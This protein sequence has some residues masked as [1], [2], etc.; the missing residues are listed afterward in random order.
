MKKFLC[1]I[2]C[3][4]MVFSTAACSTN[5]ESTIV[6][7]QSSATVETEGNTDSV[8]YDMQPIE[9][10]FGDGEGLP[11]SSDYTTVLDDGTVVDYDFT[12]MSSTITYAQIYD[13]MWNPDFYVGK[14]LK[15]QGVYYSKYFDDISSEQHYVVINDALGCC[16]QGLEFIVTEEENPSFPQADSLVEIYG[17]FEKT[18]INGLT[19]YRIVTTS[20]PVVL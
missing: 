17:T 13:M 1:L 10:H 4:I 3:L 6:M 14:V 7:A 15:V 9:G 12:K 8:F 11:T 18:V 20:N 16:P 19:F 2:L 5:Q